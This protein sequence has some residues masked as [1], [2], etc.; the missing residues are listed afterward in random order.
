MNKPD[1]LHGFNSVFAALKAGKRKFERLYLSAAEE[2]LDPKST[3]RIQK[4]FEHA[5]R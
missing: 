5:V 2:G 3:P 4:I 1:F